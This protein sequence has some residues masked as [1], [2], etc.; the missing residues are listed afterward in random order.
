MFFHASTILS[1]N[2]VHQDLQTITTTWLRWATSS[3]AFRGASQLTFTQRLLVVFFQLHRWLQVMPV[4]AEP[5]MPAVEPAEPA[6]AEPDLGDPEDVGE[7]AFR[8]LLSTLGPLESGRLQLLKTPK[9]A[10]KAR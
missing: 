7:E 10:A 1:C 8:R 4:S 6:E 5:A 3:Y 9:R 2:L